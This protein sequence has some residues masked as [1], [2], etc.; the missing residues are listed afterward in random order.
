MAFSRLLV[1]NTSVNICALRH[2]R[3]HRIFILHLLLDVLDF[4]LNSFL[5]ELRSKILWEEDLRSMVGEGTS[6]AKLR[7]AFRV[8]GGPSH[9]VVLRTLC[10]ERAEDALELQFC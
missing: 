6:G 4:I 1:V 8:L 7:D 9:S 2:P 5:I 3:F 10:S